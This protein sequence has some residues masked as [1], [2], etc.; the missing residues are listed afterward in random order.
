MENVLSDTKDAN[1]YIDDVGAFSINW[2]HHVNLLATTLRRL[3]EMALRLNPLKY[4]WA[5]KETYLAR[6]LAYT[7]R[8]NSLS[9]MDGCDHP[10]KN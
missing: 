9:A 4:E 3:R 5:V 8:L 1:V 10:L 7:T 2:D 6:L